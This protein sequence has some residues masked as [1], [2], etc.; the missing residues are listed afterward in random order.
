[1]MDTNPFPSRPPLRPPTPFDLWLARSL[2]VVFDPVMHEPL[3]PDLVALLP[4]SD[5]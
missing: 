3:P 5:A 4:T 2:R 1:M